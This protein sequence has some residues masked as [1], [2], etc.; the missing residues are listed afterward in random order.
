MKYSI[1]NYIILR[2]NILRYIKFICI[3]IMYIFYVYFTFLPQ[4]LYRKANQHGNLSITGIGLGLIYSQQ[5]FWVSNIGMCIFLYNKNNVY[6]NLNIHFYYIN[7]FLFYGCCY[8]YLLSLIKT[9]R[10]TKF[11]NLMKVDFILR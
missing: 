10:L 4:T 5:M 7:H 1:L 2:Y 3:K 9:I 6:S 11:F 8:L